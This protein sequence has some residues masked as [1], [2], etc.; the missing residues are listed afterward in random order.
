MP[1]AVE[2]L[3]PERFAAWVAAQGGSMPG[4]EEDKAAVTNE[5]T[6]QA[7][8]NVATAGEAAALEGA[9]APAAQ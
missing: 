5:P 9:A 2:A 1:I 4:A 7:D 8:D 6:V 3:P